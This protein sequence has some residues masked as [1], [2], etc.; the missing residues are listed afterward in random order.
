[1]QG[2]VIPVAVSREEYIRG[3]VIPTLCIQGRT[4]SR[5]VQCKE[6]CRCMQFLPLYPGK[7]HMQAYIIPAAVSR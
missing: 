1:M 6:F 7:E 3:C 4:T 2:R 5:E